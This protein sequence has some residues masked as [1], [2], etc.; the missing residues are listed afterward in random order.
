MRGSFLCSE[1]SEPGDFA[2][3][4]KNKICPIEV[5]SGSHKEHK[6]LD[7]FTSKYSGQILNR[8]VVYTKEYQK[9]ND[10]FCLPVYLVPFI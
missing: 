9:D 2:I 7:N 8:Y 6:S 5:K 4:K 10:I 3:S 1:S